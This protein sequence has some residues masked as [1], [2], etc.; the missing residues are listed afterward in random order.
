MPISV[1][2]TNC[3]ATLRTPDTAAGK[4]I[5][6]PKCQTIL[7]VPV[8]AA[9]E[10]KAAPIAA[11]GSRPQRQAEDRALPSPGESDGGHSDDDGEEPRKRRGKRRGKRSQASGAAGL[12]GM[13][14]GGAALLL[15]LLGLVLCFAGTTSLAFAAGG[16]GFLVGVAGAVI[17]LSSRDKS[18]AGLS[19]SGGGA[20]MSVVAI[21][22]AL[23]WLTLPSGQTVA[24]NDFKQDVAK[25]QFQPQQP[26]QNDD[27]PPLKTPS[28]TPTTATTRA[29]S[30]SKLKQLVMAMH[31]YDNQFG[32]LP[33]AAGGTGNGLSWRVAILPFL[34]QNPL[35]NKFKMDE[36]WD[37]EHNKAALDQ[38]PM[39]PFFGPPGWLENP[40]EEKKTYYQIVVGPKTAWPQPSAKPRIRSSFPDGASN[41]ILLIEGRRPVYWTAPDDVSFDGVAA[42]KVGG[43]Y[44]GDFHAAMVDGSIQYFHR[45][46]LTDELLKGLITP[47]GGENVSAALGQ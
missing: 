30:Q 35:F 8:A 47:A 38:Y 45:A 43:V 5:K 11:P 25:V 17:V 19:L 2:C 16:V 18:V 23:V 20:A 26:K 29:E 40:G 4:K 27:D 39:P 12:V 13:C 10:L 31:N 21:L 41:T 44:G 3:S 32:S 37:S 22:V 36:P 9:S 14:A 15:G 7:S 6:C 1:S 42:P 24:K 33:P 46:N 28:Q 34:E